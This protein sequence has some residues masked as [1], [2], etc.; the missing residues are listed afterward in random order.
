MNELQEGIV[1]SGNEISGTLK[2]VKGY[3]QFSPN[4]PT[5]QSGHFLALHLD[6]PPDATPT[7]EVINGDSGAKRANVGETQFVLRIKAVTQSVKFTLERPGF[8]TNTKTYTLTGLNLAQA[9]SSD[10]GEEGPSR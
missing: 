4:N 6:T 7:V 3:T 10:M 1:I 5:Q 8:K 2:Y 9:P